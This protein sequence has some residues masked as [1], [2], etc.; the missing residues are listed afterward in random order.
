M[1]LILQKK[2][3]G[4]P[5]V[6][7]FG[8]IPSIFHSILFSLKSNSYFFLFFKQKLSQ[9]NCKALIPASGT[10]FSL[11]RLSSNFHFSS[12]KALLRW[13]C[14]GFFL[15]IPF[16]SLCSA[17]QFVS[18]VTV[19]FLSGLSP[20]YVFSVAELMFA[21]NCILFLHQFLALHV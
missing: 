20:S 11:C 10:F 9:D 1:G 3:L 16:S 19:L 8:V 21:L 12:F 2:A 13:F 7:S 15:R 14:H 5:L 17:L 4:Q 18:R 6:V